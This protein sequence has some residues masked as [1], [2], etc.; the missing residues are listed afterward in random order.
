[1]NKLERILLALA[2]ALTLAVAVYVSVGEE[3]PV[4]GSVDGAYTYKNI[5]PSVASTTAAVPVRGGAGVLGSVVV[6][7][8][9]ATA[10]AIYDGAA[11]TTGATLITTL[12]ASIAAGTYTFDVAVNKGVVLAGSVG[13]DGDYV[14][15]YR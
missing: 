4:L 12:P 10:L 6:A 11:T 13:F 1:M 9:S 5:V 2:V 7:K 8:T 15:T 3:S 14:I